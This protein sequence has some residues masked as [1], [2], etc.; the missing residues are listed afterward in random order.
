M[1]QWFW[2]WIHFDANSIFYSGALVLFVVLWAMK[3]GMKQQ[4]SEQQVRKPEY[5]CNI[6]TKFTNKLI[7]QKWQEDEDKADVSEKNG[8]SGGHKQQPVKKQK[9]VRSRGAGLH[10]NAERVSFL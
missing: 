3:R 2:F 8:V 1:F 5:L 7:S 4:Q 9:Q 6:L 10:T